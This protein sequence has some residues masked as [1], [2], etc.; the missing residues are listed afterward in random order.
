MVE[1]YE[2]YY[3]QFMDC[4]WKILKLYFWWKY[5]DSSANKFGFIRNN[6]CWMLSQIHFTVE[7]GGNARQLSLSFT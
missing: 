3:T 4:Y 6:K 5:N 7:K 1:Y 2:Q